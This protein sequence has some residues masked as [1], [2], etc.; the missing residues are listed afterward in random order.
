MGVG[1]RKKGA[2]RERERN[3]KSTETYLEILR[4][5]T[6][7]YYYYVYLGKISNQYLKASCPYFKSSAVL[8][9]IGGRRP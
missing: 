4:P 1:Q 3:K 2:E 5:G 7:I 8:Y 6:C 9:I